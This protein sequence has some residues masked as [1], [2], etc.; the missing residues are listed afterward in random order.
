LIYTKNN[1]I[2]Y[3]ATDLATPFI[4]S[5]S[6][7]YIEKLNIRANWTFDNFFNYSLVQLKNKFITNYS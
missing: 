5:I 1:G 7:I 6:E 2:E 4:D 3:K